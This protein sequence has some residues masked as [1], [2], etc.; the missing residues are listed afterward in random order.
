MNAQ[1]VKD[2]YE[3]YLSSVCLNDTTH[4]LFQLYAEMR[5]LIVAW[6]I[7]SPDLYEKIM[8]LKNKADTYVSS[9]PNISK[10]TIDEL[11]VDTG[12]TGDALDD[13]SPTIK[14]CEKLY[15]S[16]TW[17]TYAAVKLKLLYDEEYK[18]AYLEK[19][20]LAELEAIRR[21]LDGNVKSCVIQELYEAMYF[22]AKCKAELSDIQ[23]DEK[24][25]DMHYE[26]DETFSGYSCVCATCHSDDNNE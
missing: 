25:I 9:S 21:E 16:E 4:V 22:C 17:E 24:A 19:K 26:N 20:N 3:G 23:L 8:I 11:D 13:A 18:K 10:M 6:P 7:D 12:F 5:H 15:A 2:I 1:L 14:Y